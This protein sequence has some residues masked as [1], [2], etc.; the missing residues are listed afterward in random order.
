M[1]ARTESKRASRH[2]VRRPSPLTADDA[3]YPA[4]VPD[5][6]RC[7]MDGD[8][9]NAGTA[10]RWS[11]GGL[12]GTE[13]VA[14][15]PVTSGAARTDHRPG[16]SKR[17]RKYR[18]APRTQPHSGVPPGQEPGCSAVGP[19][20]SRGYSLRYWLMLPSPAWRRLGLVIHRSP[21]LLGTEGGLL[22]VGWS[23]RRGS[24]IPRSARQARH[25]LR[26]ETDG[27]RPA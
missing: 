12:T 20:E 23:G 15:A 5:A 24:A 9:T 27:E 25:E 6:G 18:V 10:S 3:G 17:V 11:L 2:T 1:T 7:G 21:V 26:G 13:P 22:V 14:L 4:R 19:P 8:W 16:I